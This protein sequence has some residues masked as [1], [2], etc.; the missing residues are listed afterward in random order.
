[1]RSEFQNNS[2]DFSKYI[3]NIFSNNSIHNLNIANLYFF[4]IPANKFAMPDYK[5]QAF[6]YLS[7]DHIFAADNPP[8]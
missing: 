1:M 2:F 6:S 4:K 5:Q 7:Q 3:M 8:L